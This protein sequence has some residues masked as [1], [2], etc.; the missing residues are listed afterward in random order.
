MVEL[1]LISALFGFL[2]IVIFKALELHQRLTRESI[3]KRAYL[4][5]AQELLRMGGEGK[6]TMAK[7]GKEDERAQGKIRTWME[8]F[9]VL[10]KTFGDILGQRDGMLILE[11]ENNYQNTER[12][13]LKWKIVVEELEKKNRIPKK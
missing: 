6:L 2:C 12:E 13:L 9:E 11:D 5:A 1:V 10:Q 3:R 4:M 7:W 8:N